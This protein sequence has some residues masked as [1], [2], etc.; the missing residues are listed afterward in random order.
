MKYDS[1]SIDLT[2]SLE[3]YEGGE[4]T[5]ALQKARLC[6]GS[7]KIMSRAAIWKE[8]ILGMAV[9]KDFFRAMF[10]LLAVLI[11]LCP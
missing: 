10:C 5:L 11:S 2:D 3:T 8:E 9:S 1:F 4:E 6:Y 7:V